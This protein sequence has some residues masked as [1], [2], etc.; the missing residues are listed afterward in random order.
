MR[1]RLA[2]VAAPARDVWARPGAE[3]RIIRGITYVLLAFGL[4]AVFS[5]ST[6][7]SLNTYGNAWMVFLKQ[8]LFAAVGVGLLQ[9]AASIPIRLLRRFA[10][11]LMLGCVLLLVVVL[12]IGTS[13]NGQRNWIPI[14]SFFTLQPSEFAK[15]GLVIFLA[16]RLAAMSRRGADARRLGAV[17]L[18]SSGAVMA[19]IL[20]EKDM[21]NLLVFAGLMLALLFAVGYPIGAITG[22]A[23]AG[24]AII[25]AILMLGPSYRAERILSWRDPYADPQGVGWQ[26]IHGNYALALGGMFGQ[27]PG[28]SKEKWGALPEAH[29]DFIL[30]VIGEEYGFIGTC[31]TIGLILTLLMLLVR[32]AIQI[33]NDPFRRIFIGGVASWIFVQTV[34]NVGAVIGFLPIIGVTLPLVSYGGSSLLPLLVALG[35]VVRCLTEPLQQEATE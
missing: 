29:T 33:Q 32:V 12:V 20:L 25:A 19:L 6:V 5:A 23:A 17:V 34:F 11:V 30:A 15:L 1:Q 16:D 21:G 24:A 31:I 4:A 14:F 10:T 26:F 7:E 9:L 22:I 13:I 35:I 3:P 2:A 27:G 18:V 8:L 28:A